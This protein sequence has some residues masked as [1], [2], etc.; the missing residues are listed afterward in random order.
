MPPNTGEFSFQDLESTFD[1]RSLD[2]K[3]AQP[4]QQ[5]AARTSYWDWDDNLFA[6][7]SN[8]EEKKECGAYECDGYSDSY[9]EWTTVDQSSS[10]RNVSEEIDKHD[11]LRRILLEEEIRQCL[12]VDRVVKQLVEDSNR[13]KCEI[14][15]CVDENDWH[16]EEA[17]RYWYCGEEGS[18]VGEVRLDLKVECIEKRLLADANKRT[19]AQDGALCDN[20]NVTEGSDNGYWDWD[21]EDV[22]CSEAHLIGEF[23]NELDKQEWLSKIVLEEEIRRRLVV[24]NIEKC[25]LRDARMQAHACKENEIK[26]NHN[27]CN[28][29]WSR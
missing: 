20:I 12:M 24:G 2:S 9:W 3:F 11:L 26:V 8:A 17:E 10:V 15:E 13:D 28:E 23:C 18:C 21:E 19:C 25:L 29:Y 16:S 22:S 27:G 1:W 4:S 14:I 5:S 7:E 6:D